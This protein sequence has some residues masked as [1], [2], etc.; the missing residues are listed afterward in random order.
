MTRLS[1]ALSR[2]IEFPSAETPRSASP[3]KKLKPIFL[4]AVSG[5]SPGH[6][7]LTQHKAIRPI[8]SRPSERRMS[9]RAGAWSLIRSTSFKSFQHDVLIPSRTGSMRPFYRALSSSTL[10]AC[11]RHQVEVRNRKDLI[12]DHIRVLEQGRRRFSTSP[13]QKHGHIDPPKPGEEY[14]N[15]SIQWRKKHC[16][17]LIACADF[18]SLLLTKRVNAT[19]LR[20]Q[21]EITCWILRRQT[22]LRWRVSQEGTTDAAALRSARV[23]S[24][25]VSQENQAN[26][27]HF[28]APVAAP[29]PAP[30]AM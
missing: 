6:L 26:I 30:P 17:K 22:I 16:G 7:P 21:R 13:F 1:L 23:R 11:R 27:C 25:A 29:V 20:F 10:S 18:M 2:G 15:P 4:A 5:N 19:P 24:A 12:R 28:Q 3:P 9:G 8:A 14:D